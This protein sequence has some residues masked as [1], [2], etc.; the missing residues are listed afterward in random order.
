MFQVEVQDW[1]SGKRES[2]MS[3]VQRPILLVS[4]MIFVLFR[5][6]T[7]TSLRNSFFLP[8]SLRLLKSRFLTLL[9]TSLNLLT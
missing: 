4:K 7:D 1:L 3:T 8:P 5:Q 2:E 9:S 6:T